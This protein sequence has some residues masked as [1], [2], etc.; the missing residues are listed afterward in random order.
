M[1]P[2]RACVERRSSGTPSMPLTRD[3]PPSVPSLVFGL[4]TAMSVM[5]GAGAAVVVVG[6]HSARAVSTAAAVAVVVVGD[7]GGAG[8]RRSWIENGATAARM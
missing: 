6:V 5:V 1:A 2:T 7:V 8:S 3:H 4:F